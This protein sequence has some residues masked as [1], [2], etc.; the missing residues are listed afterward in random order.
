MENIE[1]ILGLH[2][3]QLDKFNNLATQGLNSGM[4]SDPVNPALPPGNKLTGGKFNNIIVRFLSSGYS[5]PTTLPEASPC[6]KQINH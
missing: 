4:F 1:A 2:S 5:K 3:T 6:I